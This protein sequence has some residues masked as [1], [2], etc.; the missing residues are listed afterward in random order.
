[1]VTY[2]AFFS[3]GLLAS[4]SQSRALTP[5]P[6]SSPI[7]IPSSPGDPMGADV[8]RGTPT[9]PNLDDVDMQ[10]TPN[11]AQLNPP[12]KE[13]PRLRK[14][15]SSVTLCASPMNAIKSPMRNAGAA[16]HRAINATSSP[17]RSRSGSLSTD[18]LGG[19]TV[20][21]TTAGGRKRSSSGTASIR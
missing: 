10:V 16:L 17:N 4:Y 19:G 13:R 14:R 7:L 1:M 18:V 8:G 3:S 6:P 12:A 21:G 20:Q 2:S 9:T 11:A 15:R 5:A